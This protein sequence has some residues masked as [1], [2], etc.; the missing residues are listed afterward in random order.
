MK[1]IVNKQISYLIHLISCVLDDK[2]PEEI[3]DKAV[4]KEIYKLASCHSVANIAF[5]GVD[6]LKNKPEEELY[7]KWRETKDKAILKGITQLYERDIIIQELT[8]LGIDICPL[9]GCI[10]KE[11]YPT[12][13][14][15]TMADLDILMDSSK[16][17]QV[18]GAF[19]EM[20]YTLDHIDEEGHDVYFKKPFMNIEMH[21]FLIPQDAIQEQLIA[22][23]NN[24]W[25]RLLADKE[26]QHLYQ[27]SKEDFYIY[28]IAH[29]VKHYQLGGTGIRSFMDIYVYKRHYNAVLDWEYIFG[30][31][32]KMG[33][34]ELAVLFEKVAD[35]WF[36]DGKVDS[37]VTEA[38]QYI[39]TSG[40][41]G[42]LERG[43]AVKVENT[44]KKSK[45]MFSYTV[46]RVFPTLKTMKR[47][48][49]ILHK[50]PIM[51]PFCW[52]HRIFIVLF[53]AD[54]RKKIRIEADIIKK[55]HK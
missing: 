17:K 16:K 15:R 38:S 48:Y 1:Q 35:A 25:K 54:K 37:E 12:Q 19:R 47:S 41:Y 18:E 40:T 27:M 44:M 13:D 10:I 51:L 5:Y 6:R 24:P 29:M 43:H 9:K 36:D 42:S 4:W 3:P 34:K 28:H 45:N 32:E 52:I 8:A 2:T 55:N 39:I 31:L 30:E 49:L 53:R 20:G 11:L 21:H 50:L 26:N 33:I 22:Y 46:R 7:S 14:M 23:Y